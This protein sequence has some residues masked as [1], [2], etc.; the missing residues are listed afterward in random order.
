M[1]C[2][3]FDPMPSDLMTRLRL[4]QPLPQIHI[5]DRLAAG[6]FPAIAFPSLEP[7]GDALSQIL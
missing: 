7:F 6:C 2:M 4:V 3:A 1:A 5:F